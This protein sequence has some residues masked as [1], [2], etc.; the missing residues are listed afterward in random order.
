M[1]NR[2]VAFLHPPG[3]YKSAPF[4]F[5]GDDTLKEPEFLENEKKEITFKYQTLLKELKQER[6]EYVEVQ[7]ELQQRDGYTIALS[8]ALGDQ[9]QLTE[10]NSALRHELAE[11]TTRIE[12]IERGINRY[13]SLQHPAMISNLTKEK[14]FYQTE[15]EDQRICVTNGVEKL[16][17]GK[18][19]LGTIVCS[20]PLSRAYIVSGYVLA[21]HNIKSSLK[22]ELKE[23]FTKV[24]AKHS[25]IVMRKHPNFP[26]YQMLL[27]KRSNLLL[28]LDN[29]RKEK[30][31]VS[32]VAMQ[33][34]FSL[35]DQVECM[36]L[37]L[38]ALGGEK[39]DIESM[40]SHFSNIDMRAKP[41]ENTSE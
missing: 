37:V 30:Q 23:R 9:S 26:S 2:I 27:E 13:K 19:A 11:L 20:E 24:S 1:S 21:K 35:I 3:T 18:I 28:Q 16:Q 38:V 36:N 8:G 4:F 5:R 12:G 32:E 14:A 17:N 31:S 39:L 29:T 10:S 40:R 34:V 33:S 15:I 22:K 7:K 25:D 6:K 41:Q